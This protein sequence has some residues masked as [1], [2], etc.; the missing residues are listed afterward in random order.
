MIYDF[1][2][3]A[4]SSYGNYGA[5]A[6]LIREAG[7]RHVAFDVNR[8]ESE[9]RF[10]GQRQNTNFTVGGVSEGCYGVNGPMQGV[11]V[12]EGRNV[13]FYNGRYYLTM[14]YNAWDSPAYAMYYRSSASMAG[15]A[16]AN[17][18]VP[19]NP[20]SERRFISSVD[21]TQA[22]GAHFAGGHLF[23]A[24]GKLYAI[25]H[26]KDSGSPQ[27]TP[28]FKEMKIDSSGNFTPVSNDG[29]GGPTDVAVFLVP[30]N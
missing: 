20:S 10:M 6:P 16:L 13:L 28:Y 21:R 26:G 3:G 2:I 12:T 25:F 23:E 1:V 22:Y 29:S 4:G 8:Q 5:M 19:T 7:R 15:L 24:F 14:S 11:C 17:W 30:R 27:R 18:N 9:Y